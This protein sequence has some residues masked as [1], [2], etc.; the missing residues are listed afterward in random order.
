MCIRDSSGTGLWKPQ[1]TITN[2][3]LVASYNAY[4]DK[5][6]E[7][8]ATEIATGTIIP[9]PQSSAEFIEKASGIKSR[10]IYKK[11][12]ALDIDRMMPLIPQRADEELSDQA[13]MALQAAHKAM[14]AA[15][16]TAAEIDV[17]IVA[18][19]Y[20]QRS[21]PAVSYTHLTLPTICSV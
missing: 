18:C 11:E 14:A 3:E 15:N 4:A 16:K 20:T 6:N 21:Y 13:E 17:I 1:H 9:K 8:H 19:A 5:H 7:T 10:Y 2:Q 12:G